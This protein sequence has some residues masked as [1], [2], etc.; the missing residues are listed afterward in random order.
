M[1]Y[2]ICQN[3]NMICWII[4]SAY[5]YVIFP[6]SVLFVVCLLPV[7]DGLFPNVLEGRSRSDIALFALAGRLNRLQL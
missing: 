3:Q 6:L 5:L 4:F 2:F 1:T 7:E